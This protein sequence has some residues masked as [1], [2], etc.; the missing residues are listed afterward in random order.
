MLE[1]AAPRSAQKNGKL[2]VVVG[3]LLGLVGAALLSLPHSQEEPVALWATA[4][5]AAL[6]MS[7]KPGMGSSWRHLKEQRRSSV[8]ETR[9]F[10]TR[11]RKTV[12]SCHSLAVQAHAPAARAKF[13]Q[14]PSIRR[15]RVSWKMIRS[16]KVTC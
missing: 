2:L 9:P 8:T 15:T 6:P 3:F 16:Q 7:M 14:A 5:R 10:L 1:E 4:A 11:Q 13:S 12:L